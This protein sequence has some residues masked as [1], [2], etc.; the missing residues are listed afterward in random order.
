MVKIATWL[1]HCD[2]ECFRRIFAEFPGATLHDANIGAV[3]LAQMDGLLLSGG[4]DIAAESLNQPVPHPSPIEDADARRDEWEFRAAAG[5]LAAGKPLLAI[6]RGMQVLNVALGGTLH[7]EIPGHDGAEYDNIQILRHSEA[8][9]HKFDA[10][11]SSHH[12]ALD[13]LGGGLEVEAWSAADGIVEQVKLRD[14]PFAFGV[15]YHPERHPIYRPL[16]LD[17]IQ[18]VRDFVR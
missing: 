13:R 18:R 10:V 2:A 16:F 6:C 1:R 11:N 7:L 14:Y 5:I 3:D 15:Q 4:G 9:V 12:Q 8:A 17:F